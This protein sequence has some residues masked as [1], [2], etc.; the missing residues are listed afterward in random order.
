M[1]N[2]KSKPECE[3]WTLVD[4]SVI[5]IGSSV[6]IL[7]TLMQDVNNKANGAGREEIYENC[8]FHLIF[9]QA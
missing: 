3:L 8:T 4:S 2:T 9:L 7:T 1:H 6:V 5:S